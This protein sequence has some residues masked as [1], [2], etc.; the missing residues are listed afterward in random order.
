MSD[1]I[2]N[3]YQGSINFLRVFPPDYQS[4][5]QKKIWLAPVSERDKVWKTEGV[6]Y[7]NIEESFIELTEQRNRQAREKGFK[8]NIELFLNIYKI[9]EPDYYRLLS[10]VETVIHYCN[11]ILSTT[12]EKLPPDFYVE[13]GNHCY[14]CLI[15]K[16]P[17]NSLVDAKF[18]VYKFDD[19]IGLLKSKLKIV[20]DSESYVIRNG[21]LFEIHIDSNQNLRHQILD[22][23]HEMF[24]LQ[25]DDGIKNKYLREKGAESLEMEFY[26]RNFPNLYKALFGEFLK[27]FHRVLFE[28]ELYKNPTQNLS[29]LYADTFNRCFVGA[30][31]G[32]NK[33]YILD[34]LIIHHPFQN[35]P[36]FLA[37]ID[38]ISHVVNREYNE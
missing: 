15:N 14:V 5:L 23:V 4:K 24:H 3:K 21:D 30:S 38:L 6:L 20:G 27:V 8:S 25:I 33:S 29:K 1:N 11:H 12:K 18:L 19:K 35:L 28:I 36:H 32:E 37:Q 2:K 34:S 26:M 9:S 13:F 17:I 22:L 10:K 7:K 16:F 31:Q